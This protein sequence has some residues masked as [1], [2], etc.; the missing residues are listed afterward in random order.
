MIFFSILVTS[1]V[2]SDGNRLDNGYRTFFLIF[3]ITIL[4]FFYQVMEWLDLERNAA[5]LEKTDRKIADK[6]RAKTSADAA[7]TTGGGGGAKSSAL[8]VGMPRRKIFQT[9]ENVQNFVFCPLCVSSGKCRRYISK[10]H[11]L[12]PL[13]GVLKFVLPGNTSPC[14]T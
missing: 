2:A 7:S 6:L 4:N 11:P 13:I 3:S 8:K 14:R 1:A 9:N 12:E 10:C 5:I